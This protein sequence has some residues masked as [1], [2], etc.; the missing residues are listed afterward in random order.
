MVGCV[1]T[2]SVAVEL[3]PTD[4]VMEVGDNEMP[5]PPSEMPA[6]RLTVPANPPVLASV[7][8]DDPEPPRI[9][10]KVDGADERVKSVGAGCVTVMLWPF[11]AFA[12]V[13][14]L[15]VNWTVKDPVVL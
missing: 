15:T 10:L 1:V 12:P 6:I 13:E 2:V 9:I 8:V 4:R 14:S 3:P 7:M 5:G 11:D